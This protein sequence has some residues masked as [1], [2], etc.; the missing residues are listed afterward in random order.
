MEAWWQGLSTLTQVFS[1]AAL[2]FSVI[3]VGQLVAML[4]GI[5]HFHGHFDHGGGMHHVGNIHHVGAMHHV[6]ASS[7]AGHHAQVAHHP[8]SQGSDK[9]AFTFVSIRSLIAF[10]TLFFWAGTLYLMGGTNPALA[11]GFSVI[12][13]LVG[14]FVVSYLMYK[15]VNLEETG[16]VDLTTA[17]FEEGTVYIGVP[18]DGV[19]QVRVKVSGTISYVK[20]RSKTGEPMI[21]GT[22]VRVVGIC[23]KNVVEIESIENQKGD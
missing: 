2:F 20:A 4:F 15:R 18:P 5:G 6:E 10:G 9:V 22:R 17:L 16:N 19:G 14:M 13:G 3:A 12:W 23:D 11:I 8:D 21:R 1:L 7:G